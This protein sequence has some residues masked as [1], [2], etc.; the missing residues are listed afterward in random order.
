MKF[1]VLLSVYKNENQKYLYD[2][3]RSIYHEQT[4]KPNEIILIKDGKLNEDL[5]ACLEKI[6]LEI[7][8][9]K[10]YGY[11]E[12]KGL[13]YALNYGLSKCSH[14]YVFRMD[15]DDIAYPNRFEQQ[16]E[17]LKT[18]PNIS[19]VGSF[20]TEFNSSPG[21]ITQI[22]EV[23][24]TA[25]EVKSYKYLR[26]PFNHMT[27]LYR[28]SDV[29]DVGGYIEISGYEDYYLWFRLLNYYEGANIS[30]PLVHARIGNNMIKRR[31]GI[32]YLIKE[33]RFQLILLEENLIPLHIFIRNIALRGLVRIL[34]VNALKF[35]YRQL[36]RK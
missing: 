18:N 27:V 7:P 30:T 36:L 21:D 19:I 34:P 5:D 13:G 6:A 3:L 16:T 9:L 32:E 14:E 24:L 2:A 25:M 11:T 31:Q 1:S 17:F 29:Q 26:N 10:V 35:F 23:P 33:Y 4:L 15:T 20:I 8:V 22:R 28:K 12:N